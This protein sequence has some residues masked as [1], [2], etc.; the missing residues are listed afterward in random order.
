MSMPRARSDPTTGSGKF[1]SAESEW[2]RSSSVLKNVAVN[3]FRMKAIVGE[4]RANIVR[5][6]PGILRDNVAVAHAKLA[7]AYE[8]PDGDARIAEAGRTTH[9]AGSVFDHRHRSI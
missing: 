8:D 1:S 7:H 2:G 6:K 3:F 4:R 5:R 9:N